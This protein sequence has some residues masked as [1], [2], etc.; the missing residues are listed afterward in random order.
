VA[1]RPSD[2]IIVKIDGG[3]P[4]RFDGAMY[5]MSGIRELL[6]RGEK[7]IADTAYQN[8][9]ELITPIRTP[10]SDQKKY[11][12]LVSSVRSIVE[13]T[14]ARMKVFHVLCSPWRHNLELHYAMFTAIAN[15]ANITIQYRPLVKQTNPH[16]LGCL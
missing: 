3:V 13:N 9:A 4:R 11:N 14:F 2:G 8:Y 7:G 15:I 6:V 5:S 16:Y 12:V 1:V 10:S